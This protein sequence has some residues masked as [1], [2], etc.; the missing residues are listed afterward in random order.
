MKDLQDLYEIVVNGYQNGELE[1]AIKMQPH[2]YAHQLWNLYKY[3]LKFFTKRLLEQDLQNGQ[4]LCNPM[5]VFN[6][7]IVKFT[8]IH[9]SGVPKILLPTGRPSSPTDSSDDSYCKGKC[10]TPEQGSPEV[11]KIKKNK[12]QKDPKQK[13]WKDNPKFDPALRTAKTK[14]CPST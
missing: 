9:T 10:K 6:L 4:K 13:Q 11:Q 12:H 1:A 14:Y 8:A 7:E 3:V 5:E 2:W